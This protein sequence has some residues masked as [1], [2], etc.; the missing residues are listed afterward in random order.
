MDVHI[1]N[2]ENIHKVSLLQSA[3]TEAEGSFGDF[4]PARF[5]NEK[6]NFCLLFATV[7]APASP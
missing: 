6:K 1:P 3:A 4:V 5:F 2:S 7:K